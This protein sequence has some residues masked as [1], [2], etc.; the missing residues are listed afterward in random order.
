MSSRE[1]TEQEHGAAAKENVPNHVNF[2]KLVKSYLLFKVTLRIL[3]LCL[4]V[5]ASDDK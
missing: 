1:V 2:K 3:A 4:Q 5:Q